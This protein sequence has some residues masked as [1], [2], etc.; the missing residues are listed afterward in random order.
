MKLRSVLLVC[1]LVLAPSVSARAQQEQIVRLILNITKGSPATPGN[2]GFLRLAEREAATA[3]EQLDLALAAEDF[4]ALRSRTSDLLHVIDP[5]LEAEGPGTGTGLLYAVAAINANLTIASEM[6][7]ASANLKTQAQRAITASDNVIEWS[8]QVLDAA[9][10]AQ[11][12]PS[13][14]EARASLMSIS[15]TLNNII[16][17]HDADKDGKIGWQLGEGGLPQVRKYVEYHA[18][19]E[20]L[21]PG[22]F[23]P[24]D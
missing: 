17:G 10:L 8:Q 9:K 2:I 1:L 13:I 3:L 4:A 11:M 12:V 23:K 20:G 14:V 6:E 22:F 24:T 5:S 21:T 19:G 18:Q 7:G 15:R 16:Y